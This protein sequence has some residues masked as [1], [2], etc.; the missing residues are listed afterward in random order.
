MIKTMKKFMLMLAGCVAILGLSTGN[1]AAQNR[2][3]FD[4][5]QFR[6]R[7]LDGLRDQLDV[8]DDAEWK[9]LEIAIGKVFDARQDIGF[10]GGGMRFGRGN[11][12]GGNGTNVT[13]TASS[14]TTIATDQGGQNRRRGGFGGTP[15]PE[16]EDLQK[17]I[18]AKAPASEIKAKLAKLREANKAKEAKLESA[19]EDLRKLLSSRQEATAV[20]A[21]L[22][23]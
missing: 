7:M 14:G 12:G 9:V 23:K 3:N 2:G 10:G 21:G 13:A 5:A 8:K 18:E 15:S 19:Q 1:L 20:L 22:L 11:R 6:Q 4:P 16:A 17:A